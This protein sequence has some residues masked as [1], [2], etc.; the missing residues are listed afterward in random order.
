MTKPIG[1]KL[2]EGR[3]AEIYEHGPGRVLRIDR[4]GRSLAHEAEV[5]RHVRAAGYPVPEV[6][7]AGDGFMVMERVDGPTM[8][9]ATV[10]APH[11]TGHHGRLLADLHRRLHALPAPPWLTPAALA[12]DRVLHGDLHPLNVLMAADGPVVIDWTNARRGA[13]ALDVADAWVLLATAEVPG[14]RAARTVARLG[15]RAF[16]RAFL[17]GVDQEE[18]RR[19]LPAAVDRRLADPNT[20]EGERARMRRLVHRAPG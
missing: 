18:A 7:D 14:S 8:L 16:L 2:A 5:M 19:A 17:A 6:H 13:P 15:T 12:G 9:D 1:P 20:T 10:R 4:D 3:D 11:R